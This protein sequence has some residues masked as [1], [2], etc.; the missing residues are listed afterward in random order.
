MNYLKT[1]L[2]FASLIYCFGTQSQ[3]R[4]VEFN[5]FDKNGKKHGYWKMYVDSNLNQVTDT[6]KAIWYYY[7]M[8]HHGE[9]FRG[10][11]DDFIDKK[12]LNEV[13]FL[14]RPKIKKDTI[15]PVNGLL[16]IETVNNITHSLTF[17]NGSLMNN[18]IIFGKSGTS[19]EELD[20]SKNYK[21]NPYSYYYQSP[22][23]FG[24]K[25]KKGYFYYE[26][27]K[28]RRKRD[29]EKFKVETTRYDADSSQLLYN[30]N[31]HGNYNSILKSTERGYI[32]KTPDNYN[33]KMSNHSANLIID[34]SKYIYEDY[35]QKVNG[36]LTVLDSNTIHFHPKKVIKKSGFNE[37]HSFLKLEGRYNFKKTKKRYYLSKAKEFNFIEYEFKYGA[38]NWFEEK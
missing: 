2:I 13:T 24:K 31:Y 37:K 9:T 33:N 11:I 15:L 12:A 25:I 29:F 21:N 4:K 38:P 8:I 26:P 5:S 30:G 28:K 27:N 1:V 18:F 23:A 14:S 34:S 3:N 32:P 20:Y 6:S 19:W 10:Y 16:K 7:K 36:T 17:K 22:T 35:F